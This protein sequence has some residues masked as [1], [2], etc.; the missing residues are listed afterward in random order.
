M[1]GIK[2][3]MFSNEKVISL[4][5][6]VAGVKENSIFLNFVKILFSL[7]PDVVYPIC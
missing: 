2:N 5:L 4:L 1:M 3:I 6:L 7:E